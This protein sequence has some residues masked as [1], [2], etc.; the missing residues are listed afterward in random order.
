MTLAKRHYCSL[1][2]D[3]T[4]TN[5]EAERILREVD[6]VC[7]LILDF[8]ESDALRVEAR[9]V[10]IVDNRRLGVN[11]CDRVG[12]MDICRT[13]LGKECHR[14]LHGRTCPRAENSVAF[15]HS[16]DQPNAH[17]LLTWTPILIDHPPSSLKATPVMVSVGSV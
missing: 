5:S 3:G 12:G 15:Q 10:D 11:G 17:R 2:V 14:Q 6:F 9:S 16:H 1:L 4:L 8:V 13:E 7:V